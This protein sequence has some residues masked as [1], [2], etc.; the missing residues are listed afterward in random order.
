MTIFSETIKDEY[1]F[2]KKDIQIDGS[3]FYDTPSKKRGGF[4]ENDKFDFIKKKISCRNKG[5]R[6]IVKEEDQVKIED[7]QEYAGGNLSKRNFTHIK[8]S[9]NSKNSHKNPGEI[10]WSNDGNH[11]RHYDSNVD[12]YFPRQESSHISISSNDIDFT[13]KK[14]PMVFDSNI[15]TPH[16]ETEYNPNNSL[17]PISRAARSMD[18]NCYKK[19]LHKKRFLKKITDEEFEYWCNLTKKNYAKPKP[20]VKEEDALDVYK[21]MKDVWSC[22]PG[23]RFFWEFKRKPGAKKPKSQKRGKSKNQKL[24]DNSVNNNNQKYKITRIYNPPIVSQFWFI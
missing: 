12:V 4:A 22:I 10:N 21:K 7:D 16:C 6:F 3:V 5:D 14:G 17:A 11:Q 9:E 2:L 20:I 13:P 1:C 15:F 24:D 19:V 18:F 8:V 23:N